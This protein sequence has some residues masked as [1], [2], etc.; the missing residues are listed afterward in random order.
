[1]Y[2]LQIK[3]WH[4]FLPKEMP[5]ID[6]RTKKSPII[7]KTQHRNTVL[8]LIKSSQLVIV[9]FNCGTSYD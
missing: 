5:V 2:A 4:I 3:N 8:A 1:M 6:L 9:P 7:M